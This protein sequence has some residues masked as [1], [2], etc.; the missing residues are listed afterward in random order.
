MSASSSS[1]IR[2]AARCAHFGSCGGCAIQDL[3]Y[4]D[5]LSLKAGRVSELLAP[6]GLS[7][8]K[9]HASPS[10]WYYRNKMEFSFGDVYPPVAGGPTTLLGLKAKG[11][12][13][14]VLDLKECHLLSKETGALLGSVRAWAEREKV[15]PYNTRKHTG[16]LRHLVVRESKNGA[17]RLVSLVTAPGDLPKASF[18]GAVHEA[19]PATTVL[20]GTNGKLSDTAIA[21]QTEVLEGPGHIAETLRFPEG[22]LRFRISPQAFFQT[23]TLG[24][25]TLYGILRGWVKE[26]GA[27][28]VLDL[29]CGGGGIALSVAGLCGEAVGVESNPSAVA[30][31]KANAAL[32]GI[33]NAKFFAGQVEALL[34]ALIALGVQA[35]IVDP[36]RAGLHKKVVEALLETGPALLFY[37]SCNPEALAR[38]LGL[39][40]ERYRADR[41]E[42]VDL[43]PHTE[44]VET[45]VWLKRAG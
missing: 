27:E 5:Q 36:P 17:D 24:A 30:D 34:P 40:Q 26:S 38:D 9:T 11:R 28:K 19:Y 2:I 35:A 43:F 39:L 15:P 21:D 25:Q 18:L 20:W 1:P 42:V 10:A 29:Y 33:D 32:N 12:W 31:A 8:A 14:D 7:P 23:N 45:V 41:V 4:E 3:S 44:H 22:E 13:Y 6:L 16:F 37:V